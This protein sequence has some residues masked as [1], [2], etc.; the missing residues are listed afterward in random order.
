[1]DQY[2]TIIKNSEYH[3]IEKR[4]EFIGYAFPCSTVE[5]VNERINEIK[6][7]HSDATHNVYAYILRDNNTARFNDDGEPHGTAGVPVLEVIRKEGLIDTLIVVT[8][9]FGGTLLGAGGLVRAYSAAAKGAID[10]AGS[11]ILVPYVDIIAKCEYQDYGRLEYELGKM[12]IEISNT[13]FTD[14]ILVTLHFPED[15]LPLVEKKL[16]EILCN[17]KKYFPESITMGPKR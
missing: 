4:S 6:Q 1:M 12:S 11:C 8:R 10:E 2:K 16:N 9:Y 7:K 14:K 15:E 3:M 13:E 5:Q 17:S